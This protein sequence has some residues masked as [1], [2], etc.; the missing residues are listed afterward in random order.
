MNPVSS[1]QQTPSYKCI[2]HQITSSSLQKV[3]PT[4]AIPLSPSLLLIGCLDGSLKIYNWRTEKVLNT[5][6]SPSS[7]NDAI[8]QL[9]PAN[10]YNVQHLSH[11]KILR[12]ISVSKK[13]IAYLWEIVLSQN[14]GENSFDTSIRI[15]ICR[16]EGMFVVEKNSSSS[17]GARSPPTVGSNSGA[18]SIAGGA[19]ALSNDF[20]WWDHVFLDFDAHRQ[21]FLWFVPTGFKN[22]SRCT[23]LLWDLRLS[24]QLRKKKSTVSKQDPYIVFFPSIDV[25]V[26][27]L[28]AWTHPAF[29]TQ[30]LLCALISQTGDLYLQIV[31]LEIDCK[32]GRSA[33]AYGWS[34]TSLP[35][36][37]Q[38]E[39]ESVA[40]PVIRSYRILNHRRLNTSTLLIVTT[41]GTIRLEISLDRGGIAKIGT[42]PCAYYLNPFTY[43]SDWGRAVLS[44][45]QSMI[46]WKP[47]DIGDKNPQGNLEALVN[48]KSKQQITIYHSQPSNVPVEI[49]K[50]STRL[51][52]HFYESPSGKFLCLYWV[53][54]LQY[55]ILHIVTSLRKG[56]SFAPAVASGVNILDFCWVGNDDVFALLHPPLDTSKGNTDPV[57]TN[58]NESSM[59]PITPISNTRSV[60]SV[61]VKNFRKNFNIGR[62]K[63]NDRTTIPTAQTNRP[64]QDSESSNSSDRHVPRVEL[65]LL[66][67]VTE[68]AA[69]L[70]SIAAAT[71]RSIGNVS[72]RSGNLFPP[73]ALFGGP[74]LCVVSRDTVNSSD[75]QAGNGVA[76]F[77]ALKFGEETT[78]K[79]FVHSGP[80]LPCPDLCEWDETGTLCALV[81]QGFIAIY[82]SKEDTFVLLGNILLGAPSERQV[83]VI[84]LKFIHGTLY[85]TTRTTVQCIFLG[86][87]EDETGICHLDS[88]VLASAE[89]P[90]GMSKNSILA[91]PTIIL[92]LNHPTILGYQSGSLLVSTVNGVC[93]I[94]LNHPILRIGTLLAAGHTT[95]AK[96][97]VEA[98]VPDHH[99]GLADFLCRRGAANLAA[100]HCIGLSL[101]TLIDLCLRYN[102]VDR[103][104]Q[105]VTD[106]GVKGLRQI[107]NGRAVT[108]DILG[109][110]QHGNS[111]LIC[112]AAFLLG[113]G[114]VEMVHE[115]ALE[116]LKIGPEAKLEAIALTSLL[117]AAWPKKA[118]KLLQEA[119]KE[120]TNESISSHGQENP[121]VP[122]L[123]K[124]I[125]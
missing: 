90:S 50:R 76:Y 44:A 109:P 55:E 100:N 107:D 36:L 40:I 111:F 9:V 23:L 84:D 37:I 61:A 35:A 56:D 53:D 51:P 52:P 60:G 45:N 80:T 6:Q 98:I 91:P 41:S 38:K 39:V 69:E 25:P 31:N 108:V 92:T 18:S 33:K 72:L 17:L 29:P 13:S 5:T 26:S 75:K 63:Q 117:L 57:I 46:Y 42:R 104:V 86:D 101:E 78:A 120:S 112:V 19:M 99:E 10:R 47:L 85:C 4:A 93:A 77:Y 83:A 94:S 30:C 43:G 27:L 82:R 70:G 113:N 12:V 20:S 88:F 28:A 96:K 32:P 15:P 81:V 7:K 115:L 64:L 121:V 119:V 95:R 24:A 87:L 62:Q 14:I 71:A 21:F 118:R 22:S 2:V 65:K 97:W 3:V 124:Y 103:L 102:L 34:E 11:R 74:N 125:L 67:G 73:T 105:L 79:N 49:Q 54:E 123:R 114:Q 66:I 16:M 122:L 48:S 116:C 110:Q 58:Y 68:N 89:G 1:H 8:F 59:S 106:C